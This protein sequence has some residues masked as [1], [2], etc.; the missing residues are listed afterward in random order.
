MP[1]VCASRTHTHTHTRVDGW[2]WRISHWRGYTWTCV[3]FYGFHVARHSHA[4]GGFHVARHFACECTFDLPM[5]TARCARTHA[6]WPPALEEFFKIALAFTIKL[7]SLP[8]NLACGL[9]GVTFEE[10]QLIYLVS[11]GDAPSS[12]F[13]KRFFSNCL[14][15][16]YTDFCN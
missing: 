7:R 13:K 5:P 12:F 6:Q 14:L 1:S 10:I 4:N 15:S 2:A 8:G 11:P 16:L 9:V 3:R